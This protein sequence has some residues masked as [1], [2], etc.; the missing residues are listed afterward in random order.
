MFVFSHEI[1]VGLFSLGVGTAGT[2]MAISTVAVHH[3]KTHPQ[4]SKPVLLLLNI[5]LEAAQELL[6]SVQEW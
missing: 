5:V 2:V 3:V 6:W 4:L 1:H